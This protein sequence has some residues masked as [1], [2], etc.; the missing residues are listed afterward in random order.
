MNQAFPLCFCILQV[1]KNWTVGRPGLHKHICHL[2]AGGNGTAG[3]AMA[4]PDFEGEKN[5]VAWILTYACAIGWPFRAVRH[6]L[7]RLR[8][9]Q[10]FKA[11]KVAM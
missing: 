8:G 11:F 6:R 5:G 7:G 4:I 1:I 10:V 3:T 9:L 2:R